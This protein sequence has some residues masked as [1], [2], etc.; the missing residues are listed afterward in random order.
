M[1]SITFSYESNETI[2]ENNGIFLNGTNPIHNIATGEIIGKIAFTY[3]SQNLWD[4][5]GN[6]KYF[7]KLSISI[8]LNFLQD[9]KNSQLNS[10]DSIIYF[11]SN[12]P[13]T[14]Q[15]NG[16]TFESKITS[17]TIPVS[18]DAKLKI[19]VTQTGTRIYELNF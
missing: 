9:I 8:L 19:S 14:R 11:E 13:L 15:L 1:P 12:E 16:T 7:N 3:Y 6:I 5:N 17:S 4:A 2:R 10:L 18:P